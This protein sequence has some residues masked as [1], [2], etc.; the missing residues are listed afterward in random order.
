MRRCRTSTC[1]DLT[2]QE[3]I[4]LVRLNTIE[5]N[6]EPDNE[7]D[8]IL[9]EKNYSYA[10]SKAAYNIIFK[11]FKNRKFFLMNMQYIA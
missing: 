8:I 9:A 1:D 6:E 4:D 7:K 3:I 5:S 11:Y 2:D 10:D